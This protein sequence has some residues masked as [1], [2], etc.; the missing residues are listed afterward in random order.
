MAYVQEFCAKQT[1]LPLQ[2]P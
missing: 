1:G 2:I